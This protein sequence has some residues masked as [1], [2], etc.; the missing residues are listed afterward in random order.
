M[1]TIR[2]IELFAGYGSQAMALKNLELPFEHY[3]VV[4]F[5]EY[6]IRS[7]N[8]V[9]GTDFPK[10]DI[11]DIH[12]ADLGITDT[13]K[14]T[15]LMTYSFPCTDLSIAG[16]RQ[17]MGRESGTRSGLLWEVER[18]LKECSELPQFLL[19]ENVP[20]IHNE[21]NIKDFAEWLRFLEN[22]GY[23]NKW[24]DLNAKDYG[25]PQSRNRCFVVSWLDKSFS[26]SFP[27][28][29]QLDKSM[30]DY[31]EDAVDDKYY[32][33]GDRVDKLVAELVENGVER[34]R[35]RESYT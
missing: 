24:Q 9:H 4:E 12:G 10:I 8:A 21:Q 16:T 17:G 11:R 1:K 20:M 26:Y 7:Y 13:D 28:P 25:I 23:R 30:K 18:L 3:R 19:M 35:E 34:E 32:L 31:L 2:L 22:L 27:L 14:F 15:Y 5:D 29:I 6:A 33:T